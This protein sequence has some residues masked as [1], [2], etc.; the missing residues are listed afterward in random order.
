MDSLAANE[1]RS[2]SDVDINSDLELSG[3]N[4]PTKLRDGNLAV[5]IRSAQGRVERARL[6]LAAAEVEL[7]RL[8]RIQQQQREDVVRDKV[9]KLA[10][11]LGEPRPWDED[12]RRLAKTVFGIE[13]FR[14]FQQEAINATMEGLDLFALMPTGSGKSLIYQ[15]SA[16]LLGGITLVVSPLVALMLDQVQYLQKCGVLAKMLASNISKD[17]TKETM[18]FIQN[19]GSSDGKGALIFA[20]P[21]K[22][23]NSK[24]LMN[25][26]EK[27]NEQGK[28]KRFV[29]DEAHCCSQWGHDFRKDFAELGRLRT[30]FPRVPMVLLTATAG[31]KVREDVQRIL[32]VTSPVLLK[33]PMNRQNLYYEVRPK[34]TD[35]EV[36]KDIL[37]MATSSEYK[38]SSGIIYVFS[39]KEAESLALKL[40]LAGVSASAYH[41][42][43]ESFERMDIQLKW[44]NNRIRIVV[45]TIAFG[46][47]INKPDVRFVIHHTISKSLESYYQESGRG[48]RDGLP[49]ECVLYWRPADLT[50]LSS[51]QADSANRST[52]I[53]LLYDMCKYAA[54]AECR[55]KFILSYFREGPFAKGDQSH[56]CDIC[57][58][59][60][61]LERAEV[62]DLAKSLSLVARRVADAAQKTTDLP[63]VNQLVDVWGGT[64]ATAKRLRGPEPIAPKS[65]SK[66]NRVA[67]VVQLLLDG[68]FQEEFHYTVYSVISY[69]Q[70]EDSMCDALIAGNLRVYMTVPAESKFSDSKPGRAASGAP[71]HAGRKRP[72]MIADDSEEETASTAGDPND[73]LIIGDD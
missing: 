5:A 18:T 32:R 29:I 22:I 47:G 17:E 13:S 58:N 11:G 59:R 52:A 69:I 35:D 36:L 9:N 43:L 2:P 60:S 24:T 19:G 63:T 7:S 20:S 10:A 67:L 51:M 8:K 61:K 44:T 71:R 15:V 54:A 70:P 48:G 12:V 62:T 46:L 73:V 40:Q 57:S 16:V 53:R 3:D 23:V 4:A 68:V 33:A 1:G 30:H 41:A 49:A 27:A 21:E 42:N 38:R 34:G 72:K 6:E 66:Q 14:A 45:A 37:E 56:C 28:L 55:R 25:K 39:R 64:G 26:L 50:R 31:V 65:L